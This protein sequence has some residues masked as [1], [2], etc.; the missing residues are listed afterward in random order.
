VRELDL[1]P[2]ADSASENATTTVPLRFP[3]MTGRRVRVTIVGARVQLATRESTGDTVAAPVGI[4]ELGIPG[5]Q[6]TPAPTDMPGPCRADLLAIDGRAVPVRISGRTSAAGNLS[7][8]AVAACDPHDPSRVP[9]VTLGPGH[10]LV[11]TSE[12]VRTGLQLD[13]VV[14]ASAAGGEPLAVAGGRVTGLGRAPRPTPS[15]TVV[16]NGETRMRVHVSGADAP[17]WLVLGQ[18]QSAGWKATIAHS[19]SLGASRL[20][21]G[22]ANG[23]LVHPDRASFDVVLEWTPQ[24]QVWTALWI[25]V[26]AA[27]GCLALIGWSLVRGRRVARVTTDAPSDA[28][29]RVE[30]PSEP[31]IGR[32]IRPRDRV[33]VPVLVGLAAALVVA[34]WVGALAAAAVVLMQWCPSLRALVALAPVVLISLVTV[35]VVYL[36]HHFRFPPVFEWPTFFPLARPLGWLAVIFLAVDVVVE[37]AQSPPAGDLPEM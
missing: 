7:G 31:R 17:F 35:Y 29:V 32:V 4:A 1:P 26:A 30:W 6:V 20:V 19:G 24:R 11:R 10:H 15:V 27:L 9:T 12:G 28:E 8:L 18:S 13:R 14:L 25:S 37:R 34:P 3:P 23:W 36:Q 16:N 33:V 5:L 22:Y 21:D 2:V